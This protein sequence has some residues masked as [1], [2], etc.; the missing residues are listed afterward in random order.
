MKTTPTLIE[1][2]LHDLGDGFSVRRLLP[3]LPARRF[4]PVPGDTE[5]FIPLP[6]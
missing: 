5:E 3:A 4:D 6:P 1:G 2:H